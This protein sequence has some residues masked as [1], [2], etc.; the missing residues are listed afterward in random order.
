MH[1]ETQ[2]HT[3]RIEIHQSQI[4][5]HDLLNPLK[6]FPNRSIKM[7]DGREK[8]N[9]KNCCQNAELNG[10]LLKSWLLEIITPWATLLNYGKC[11]L[12]IIVMRFKIYD[13]IYVQHL[14]VNMAPV[15][16]CYENLAELQQ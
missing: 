5:N 1:L 7:I 15:S 4:T 2:K 10:T 8:R 12:S 3:K 16:L 13:Q 14:Q 9:V 11:S 6:L